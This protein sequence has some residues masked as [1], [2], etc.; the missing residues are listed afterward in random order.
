MNF[1]RKQKGKGDYSF[2]Q[3]NYGGK[4]NQLLSVGPPD[5]QMQ[6]LMRE[7]EGMVK[8]LRD[9][10]DKLRSKLATLADDKDLLEKEIQK[11]KRNLEDSKAEADDRNKWR[12]KALDLENN[13]ADL[14]DQFDNLKKKKQKKDDETQEENERL[15]RE[16]RRFE[17]KI[18]E[19]EKE[20]RD[21]GQ[22]QKN[23]KGD[24]E[25]LLRNLKGNPGDANQ[26][27][28][29]LQEII[30]K[31]DELYKKSNVNIL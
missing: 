19:K 21:L 18:R 16:I 14:Q 28:E 8:D 27:K 9:S 2:G 26:N 31:V 13:L 4:D 17:E 23:S 7:K 15:E 3:N 11:L 22:R 29:L 24:L 25:D 6:N 1:H 12:R 20:I 5:Q 30:K 10:N